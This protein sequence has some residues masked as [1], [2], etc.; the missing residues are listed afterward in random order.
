MEVEV[1]K[2]APLKKEGEKRNHFKN[3]II[4]NYPTIP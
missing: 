2:R 4:T 3:L 1:L